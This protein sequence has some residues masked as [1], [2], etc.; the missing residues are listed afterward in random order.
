MVLLANN[1]IFADG[2]VELARTVS[3]FAG[4]TIGQLGGIRGVESLVVIGFIV[5]FAACLY[6][7]KK[8]NG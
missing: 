8:I 2:A 1:S 3:A 7:I 6:E 5:G 4:Q